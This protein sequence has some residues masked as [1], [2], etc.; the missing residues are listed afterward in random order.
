M[1]KSYLNPQIVSRVLVDLEKIIIGT[2][3]IGQDY[4]A[5]YPVILYGSL[6]LLSPSNN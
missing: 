6:G 2:Y 5:N 4:C 3:N 1:D